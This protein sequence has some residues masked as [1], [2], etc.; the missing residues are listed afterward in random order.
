MRY[1]C[2]RQGV[3][4]EGGPQRNILTYNWVK[5][6]KKITVD[7][8]ILYHMLPILHHAIIRRL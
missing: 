8:F 6:K 3:E 7:F 2:Q 5:L 1:M 4:Q